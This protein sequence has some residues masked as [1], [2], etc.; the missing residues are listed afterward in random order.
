M[1][2]AYVS[3]D[4]PS[5]LC[6]ETKSMKRENKAFVWPSKETLPYG[7]YFMARRCVDQ[8]CLD[9]NFYAYILRLVSHE[10]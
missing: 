3:V 6:K 1:Q 2:L 7:V 5:T 10:F 8:N 9:Q 4:I